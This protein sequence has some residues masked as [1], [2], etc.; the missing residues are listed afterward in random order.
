MEIASGIICGAIKKLRSQLKN[1][2]IEIERHLEILAQQSLPK[3]VSK[4]V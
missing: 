1:P 2:P 4:Q 3:T